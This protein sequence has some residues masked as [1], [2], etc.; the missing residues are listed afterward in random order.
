M[1][2]K[3]E[4]KYLV[5]TLCEGE[6]WAIHGAMRCF[7][8]NEL[9]R[10]MWRIKKRGTKKYKKEFDEI[11]EALDGFDE[12]INML[13]NMIYKF[14]KVRITEEVVAVDNVDDENV[15]DADTFFRDHQGNGGNQ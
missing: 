1:E 9:R 7:L 3:E 2:R 14:D 12:Y 5:E 10:E 4:L 15:D 13:E 8:G 11:M 6:K